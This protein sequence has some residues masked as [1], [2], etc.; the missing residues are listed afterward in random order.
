MLSDPK[1]A[2]DK[3]TSTMK[4]ALS[5]RIDA[6]IL[7]MNWLSIREVNLRKTFREKMVPK[8]GFKQ[9]HFPVGR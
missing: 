7:K 2:F 6:V 5:R 1:S 4:E 8:P 3:L 9:I